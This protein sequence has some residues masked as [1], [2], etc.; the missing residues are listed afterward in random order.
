[1]TQLVEISII[2]SGKGSQQSFSRDSNPELLA[3]YVK[4]ILDQSQGRQANGLSLDID[5]CHCIH[6]ARRAKIMIIWPD[7]NNK[8]RRNNDYKIHGDISC[9]DLLQIKI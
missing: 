4:V 9:P 1:M 3:L 8:N 6:L 2:V 7:I 5:N